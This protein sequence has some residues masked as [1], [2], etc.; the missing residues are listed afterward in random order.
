MQR[1]RSKVS[2]A[3]RNERAEG[4]TT[5]SRA[6]PGRAE[7]SKKSAK[8][9]M[10]SSPL[11]VHEDDENEEDDM[12]AP[13]GQNP[14]EGKCVQGSGRHASREATYTELETVLD[15][16]GPCYETSRQVKETMDRALKTLGEMVKRSWAAVDE[17][18]LRE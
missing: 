2:L 16:L 8:D 13:V 15:T 7:G 4:A 10:P 9:D 6:R 12:D 11:T 1:I 18:E 14:Q 3:S 17:P 5:N